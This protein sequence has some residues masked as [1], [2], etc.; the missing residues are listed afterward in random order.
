MAHLRDQLAKKLRRRGDTSTDESGFTLIELLIVIIIVPM[1][2]FSLASGL[3]AVLTIQTSTTARIA[4]TGDSQVVGANFT[5]DVQGAAYLTTMP[6][7]SPQCGTGTQLL[8][9]EWDLDATSGNYQTVV[10][11]VTV[12]VIGPHSTTYS[13]IR[14]MCTGGNY[15]APSSTTI[16]YDLPASQ[17][18][19]TV[20]CTTSCDAT[21]SWVSTQN[22]TSVVFPIVEPQSNYSYT[23]EA[24]PADSSTAVSSGQP[25]S[26]AATTT[27][28]FATPGTGTYASTLCFVDFAPLNSA[29]NMA[30]ATNGGLEVSVSLPKNYTLYFNLALSG[31]PVNAVAFP[32]YPEAFLGNSIGGTPFYI[33]VP[34]DPALYQPNSGT[35]TTVSITGITVVNPQ[36]V[37]ATG[38]EAVGADAETTDPHETISWTSDQD[39]NLL[40]NTPSSPEGDACNA[41]SSSNPSNPGP[42]GTE[43]TGLGTKAVT[44]TST[45]QATVPRTGTTMLWAATPS[46]LVTTLHG[47][48]LEGVSFGLLLS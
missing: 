34:G 29:A 6:Q 30:A 8:G 3:Y 17:A 25:I 44:C 48:G 18:A 32:T 22:V 42:G 45:W 39:L 5:T 36:G 15:S 35:T 10:S 2:I 47:A 41:P 40:P 16:S 28:G 13:L 1:I 27:C 19:P 38:W 21:S 24:V 26:T 31:A 23:L 7:S 37:A 9:L 20:T 11:Y 43:L 33:G 46:S 14:Q 4:D 12:P